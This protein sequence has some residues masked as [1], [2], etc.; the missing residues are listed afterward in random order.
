MKI[1]IALDGTFTSLSAKAKTI[2]AAEKRAKI[3]ELQADL[4]IIKK[5]DALRVARAAAQKAKDSAKSKDALTKIR[6]LKK[7]LSSTRNSSTEVV[8]NFIKAVMDMPTGEAKTVVKL[9]K[10]SKTPAKPL[11]HAGHNKAEDAKERL[12]N[13]I[14]RL[15]SKLA[16]VPK[17]KAARYDNK[18]MDIQSEIEDAQEELKALGTKKTSARKSSYAPSTVTKTRKAVE[19]KQVDTLNLGNLSAK[20]KAT[21]KKYLKMNTHDIL[22][23][24]EGGK[25]AESRLAGRVI[26]GQLGP[27]DRDAVRAALS[28]HQNRV[29]RN[30]LRTKPDGGKADRMAAIELMKSLNKG[31]KLHG[32]IGDPRKAFELAAGIVEGDD[33]MRASAKK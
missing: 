9:D 31:D 16:K 20:D 33:A 15:E 12:Q 11:N 13:Q 1:R 5:V 4:K 18:R 26:A 32:I 29:T 27:E 7:T 3:K 22:R 19:S 24:T 2:T 23:A 25:P 30:I 6:A 28:K 10:E 17:I 14:K 21:A 8:Q